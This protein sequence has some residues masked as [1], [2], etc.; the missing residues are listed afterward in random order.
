ML[1][2]PFCENWK[3]V[4]YITGNL[5]D[6]FLY[7]GEEDTLFLL[8]RIPCNQAKNPAIRYSFFEE[9]HNV[10]LIG[11]F[12]RKAVE[13]C[14]ASTAFLLKKLRP[15]TLLIFLA[16]A[17]VAQVVATDSGGRRTGAAIGACSCRSAGR[18]GGGPSVSGS[19]A[20]AVTARWLAMSI[21]ARALLDGVAL[22][23]PARS[24]DGVGV[25]AHIARRLA[26]RLWLTHLQPDFVAQVLQQAD[27]DIVLDGRL[28]LLEHAVRLVLEFDQGVAL[29]NRAEVDAGAHDIQRIDVIH[30]QAVDHLERDGALQV[31][32][33][34]GW[35][36]RMLPPQLRMLLI[37]LS[38]PQLI[39]IEDQFDQFLLEV[40]AAHSMNVL[41]HHL[42]RHGNQLLQCGEELL[43]LLLFCDHRAGDEFV[44]QAAHLGAYHAQNALV[45]VGVFQHGP[46]VGVDHLAL[47][48]NHVI[49]VDDILTLIEVVAFDLRLRL[50]DDVGDQAVFQ[51]HILFQPHA[52]H[53]LREHIRHEAAQQFVFQREEETRLAGVALASSAAS[54]LLI[55]TARLMPLGADDVQAAQLDDSLMILFAL[56][57]LFFKEFLLLLL[58]HM[59][60]V[61]LNG[62]LFLLALI[63]R[64]FWHLTNEVY[65]LGVLAQDAIEVAG[66]VAA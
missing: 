61:V 5:Y 27:N 39:V 38:R 65:L 9:I 30:P 56:A 24:G 1:Y 47:F 58:A 29:A 51:W 21:A 57:H 8:R 40:F 60:D 36:I 25:G 28:Q 64:A 41:R 37:N 32:N 19:L 34:V 18:R 55:N 7:H 48:S 26:L 54:Q 20:G 31:A 63:R 46:A 62:F 3:F 13:A 43:K 42:L 6:L 49:I 10:L 44:Y 66:G 23:L 22:Y 59:R 45:Q 4:P 12:R 15:V 53:N 52:L 14:P 2:N 17:T 11:N 16:A 50:F 35:E 33:G